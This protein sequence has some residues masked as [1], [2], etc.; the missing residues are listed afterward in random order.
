MMRVFLL[1]IF[2]VSSL[3]AYPNFDAEMGKGTP[4]WRYVETPEDIENLRFFRAL[5]EKNVSRVSTRTVPKVLHFIWLG[6]KTFPNASLK[7]LASW[8][9]RHPGWVVKFWTDIDRPLPHARMQKVLVQESHLPHLL[10]YYYL[11]DNYGEKS[12]LLRYEILFNEGGIYIDHDLFCEKSLNGVAFDFFCG[13]EKIGPSILSSSIFPSTHLIG[14]CP[15]HP[16]FSSLFAWISKEWERMEAS[17]PGSTP[18]AIQNRVKHRSFTALH[19]AVKQRIG[20]ESYVDIVFPASFFSE[21]RKGKESF[22]THAHASTWF[23]DESSSEKKIRSE[24][25][26]IESSLGAT[27]LLL[28]SSLLLTLVM[29]FI[30]IRKR[31]AL[32]LI[33]LFWCGFAQAENFDSLMGK[34]TP[35]WSYLVR[36][37]DN[38]FLQA[39]RAVYETQIRT[40]PTKSFKIPKIIH[41]IWLGPRPFPPES[42]ENIRTWMAHHPDWTVKFWTDRDRPVP[43][44]GMQR[45]FVKNFPFMKLKH[46][47]ENSENYGE[48]SDILRYEI[49]Y[50]EGGVYADHDANS[51]RSFEPLHTTYD[52]Y[53]GLEAPHEPFVGQSITCG[54]GVIGS[55][56]HH[57]AI[58]KVIDLIAVRWDPLGRQ[59]R[60]RDSYSRTEV[61]MRRTYIALTDVLKGGAL[62][63]EGNVDIVLPAAYFF[64]KS[65]IPSLYSKHFYATAWAEDRAKKSDFQ[66]ASEKKLD[67]ILKRSKNITWLAAGLVLASALAIFTLWRQKS[68]ASTRPELGKGRGKG[69]GTTNKNHLS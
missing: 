44:K 9:D 56:P 57:P 8:I 42:V 13:L 67:K 60:G 28:L 54:N 16:I 1:L 21:D 52:F 40:P 39:C 33:P 18:T 53:C 20:S 68:S 58:K 49:L 66:K 32:L 62:N 38:T 23:Q 4:A 26:D 6:P 10:N 3:W 63:Q 15:G 19:E 29:L 64:A 7:N 22:A 47:F 24:C 25:V 31:K 61:V 30:F 48:K 17:Y 37:E 69:T 12:E 45:F 35:H 34:E 59:Y 43:C 41:F 36:E 27:E 14:A 46:C 50:R 5:Y 11:S 55:R 51:L 2:C 65:G